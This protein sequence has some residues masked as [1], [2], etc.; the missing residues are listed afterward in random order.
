M[1]VVWNL[2]QIL[3]NKQYEHKMSSFKVRT[4]HDKSHTHTV[5]KS[6]HIFM[7]W[8]YTRLK[9]IIIFVSIAFMRNIDK[10]KVVNE[11]TRKIVY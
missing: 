5:K 11:T 3:R 2:I 4:W 7:N 1:A 8:T 6:R 10:H 9:I